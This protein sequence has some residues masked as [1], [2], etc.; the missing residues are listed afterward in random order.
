MIFSGNTCRQIAWGC[1]LYSRNIFEYT[2]LPK[3]VLT[4]ITSMSLPTILT[5]ANK[6]LRNTGTVATI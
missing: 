1:A 5:L 6:R 2:A 3:E 4:R